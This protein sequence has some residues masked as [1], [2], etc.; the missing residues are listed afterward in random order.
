MTQLL[1]QIG[2][3]KDVEVLGLFDNKTKKIGEKRQDLLNLA[4]GEYLVFVDDDDRVSPDY[5][6]EV[7]SALEK[8]PDADCVVYDCI[9]TQNGL[10]PRLCKY[11]VEYNYWLSDDK[12]NWTGL[13]AHTM[14]YRSSIAKRHTYI[15]TNYQ[16]DV[17]WVKRASKDI[18]KQVRIDKVL[19]YYDYNLST[20]ESG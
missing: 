11:G 19:Y 14:V 1:N 4:R 15:P 5:I 13:P 17:D 8:N 10:T 20:T 7:L 16:E 6:K 3:R 18:K 9:W 2:D 12:K